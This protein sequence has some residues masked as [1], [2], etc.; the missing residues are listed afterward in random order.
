MINIPNVLT[1]LRFPLALLFL[2]QNTV[3]RILVI[4]LA[5]LSDG[6]DGFI[7]RRYRLAT[8]FGTLL[9]PLMDRFFVFFVIG[10]L[11][12]EGS[13]TTWQACTLLCRDFA[14]LLFGL[15][16]VFSRKLTSYRFRAIWCGKVTTFLQFVVF[17][18]LSL[19]FNM[20]SW[21]FLTFV[22]LGLFALIELYLSKD[23]KVL[24]NTP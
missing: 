7:A 9:D 6:L 19:G 14:V 4:I 24:Y 1:L 8:P 23:S 17:L 20:P 12:Q 21:F 15:Y 16:L 10:I 18:L 11:L 3:S 13:L 2:K 5:M 22:L